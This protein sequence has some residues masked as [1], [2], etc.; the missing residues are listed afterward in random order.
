M[1]YFSKLLSFS[2]LFFLCYINTLYSQIP[3]SP[4]S[5]LVV[6]KQS[7]I[8]E[9]EIS[10]KGLRLGS[11]IFIR[12]FKQTEELE[13]WIFSQKTEKFELF[14]VYPICTYGSEG[15]GP[16]L[17]EGDNFAPEGFY[18][19][20]KSQLNPYSSFHLS[21]NLGYPNKYDRIKNR[22]GSALMVHGGCASVGCYAMTD[23]AIEEI[24]TIVYKA[25]ESGQNYFRVHCFPFRMTDKNLKKFKNNRWFSFWKN[26]KE[27]YDYFELK[28]LPPD[29]DVKNGVY[30]FE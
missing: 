27:G 15:L 4:K 21:F 23:P 9:K 10:K 3:S 11:P 24:Y 20:P 13:L 6:N 1:I 14:K 18:F 17:K 2:L 22:T 28:K 5:K 8:L 29:T 16:K 30:V 12:I 19:V 25:L 26:L 7:T